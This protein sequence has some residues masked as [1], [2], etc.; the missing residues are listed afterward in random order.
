MSEGVR[1]FFQ[2]DLDWM[3]SISCTCTLAES[4][5]YHMTRAD[6]SGQIDRH[7]HW[8]WYSWVQPLIDLNAIWT[9]Q[10]A[11]MCITSVC[12]TELYSVTLGDYDLDAGY[13]EL[14]SG[15]G[16]VN[17]S[18]MLWEP[19]ISRQVCNQYDSRLLAMSGLTSHFVW[20]PHTKWIEMWPPASKHMS[21]A[22]SRLAVENRVDLPWRCI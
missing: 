16:I 21:A 17:P 11:L 8:I 2:P 20:Y 1:R 3:D 7:Y 22:L 19:W 12:P 18:S 13:E 15:M 5:P 9:N 14:A 4:P 6:N 10:S